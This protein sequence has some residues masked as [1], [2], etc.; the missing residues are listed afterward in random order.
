MLSFISVN[1]DTNIYVCAFKYI[2][3]YLLSSLAASKKSTKN[4]FK[5]ISCYLLSTG[6]K[7]AKVVG[8]LFK[9]I[10]C[11][12]LSLPQS[13]TKTFPIYLNTSHVIFYRIK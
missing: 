1:A 12:L 9:Y 6:A 3:C 4:S 2:S 8:H 10:S 5:Y 11:Y 7:H 13:A